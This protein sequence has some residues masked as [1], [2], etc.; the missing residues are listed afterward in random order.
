MA[1]LRQLWIGW[2]LEKKIYVR[3]WS[4]NQQ[5]WLV[6][7][8]FARRVLVMMSCYTGFGTVCLIPWVLYF[9]NHNRSSWKSR[10]GRE[11]ATWLSM[12]AIVLGIH[13]E[14]DLWI[15]FEE[16]YVCH[17]CPGPHNTRS[18]FRMLDINN[19]ILTL[20]FLV[21]IKSMICH[22]FTCRTHMNI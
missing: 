7:K 10:I 8:G 18:G 12:P 2:W 9:S 19:F 11:V 22:V 5:K 16:I 4:E 14:S 15:Y 17:N 3:T 1:D 13:F 6:N 21:G 20:S